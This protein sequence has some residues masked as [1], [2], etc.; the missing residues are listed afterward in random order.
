MGL[1]RGLA[2]IMGRRSPQKPQVSTQLVRTKPMFRMTF[3]NLN[4]P[5]I[6]IQ[7][8]PWA[9]LY[10]LRKGEEIEIAAECQAENPRF[11]IQEVNNTRIL[12]LWD[13]EEYFVVIE[14][15]LVHWTQCQS[16]G[17]D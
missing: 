4:E 8:D 9:G 1:M 14:G 15:N 12:T 7:V 16:M 5:R 6:H 3:R 17:S 10:E 2:A 13:S 11:D